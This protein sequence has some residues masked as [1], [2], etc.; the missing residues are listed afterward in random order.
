L[1]LVLVYGTTAGAGARRDRYWSLQLK[2]Q[3]RFR[4]QDNLLA[5]ACR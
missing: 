5:F 3:D 1:L 4:L 2:I